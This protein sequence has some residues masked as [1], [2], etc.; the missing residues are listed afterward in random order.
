MFGG[1]D[2]ETEVILTCLV[3]QSCSNFHFLTVAENTLIYRARA[4]LYYFVA[5]IRL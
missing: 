5:P 4:L 2:E 3:P 1:H